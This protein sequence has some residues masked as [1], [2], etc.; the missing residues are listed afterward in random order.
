MVLQAN[1]GGAKGRL[2]DGKAAI[3]D[4]DVNTEGKHNAIMKVK[5]PD[6]FQSQ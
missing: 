3:L 6:H 1:R 4:N 5:G 2:K